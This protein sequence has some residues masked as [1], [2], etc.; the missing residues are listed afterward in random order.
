M[1]SSLADLVVN[2]SAN[3]ASLEQGLTRASS[4]VTKFGTDITRSLEGVNSR[5][6]SVG[7]AFHGLAAIVGAD[8]S[9]KFAK[10]LVAGS[11]EAQASLVDLG[12]R[13]GASAEQISALIPAAKLSGTSLEE[14][15][16]GAGK[17]SKS[18]VE[19][20]SGTGKS[21]AAF[22]ALGFSSADAARLLR[23]PA[24]GLAE[25]ATRLSAFADDGNK[26]AAAQLLLGKSGAQLL[27]FLHDLAEVGAD[28]V[29]VTQQQ[30]EAAKALQDQWALMQISS[31]QLKQ[32]FVGEL[33]PAL[34]AM[35][36]AWADLANAPGGFRDS[37]RQLIEQG[38]IRAYAQEAA[39]NLAKLAD[40]FS[41]GPRVVRPYAEAVGFV[42]VSLFDLGKALYGVSLAFS[43]PIQGFRLL[44]EAFDEVK[45]NFAAVKATFVEGQAPLS[46]KYYDAVTKAFID[47]ALSAGDTAKAVDKAKPSLTG[48]G[49]AAQESSASLASA[50][51]AYD[52]ALAAI[53]RASTDAT[54]LVGQ[55]GIKAQLD[56]LERAFSQSL[57]GFREYYSQRTALQ[58][59]SFEIEESRLRQDIATQTELLNGLGQQLQSLAPKGN[60]FKEINEF[61]LAYYRTATQ[62]SEAQAKLIGLQGQLN[63]KQVE[64]AQVG[65]DYIEQLIKQSDG[66][67]QTNRAL[68]SQ[69]TAQQR[70]N[71][72]IGLTK[73]Q[74]IALNI[75]RVEEDRATRNLL[76][77]T[78]AV[79]AYYDAQIDGLKRLGD[80]T[81]K[82]E[83]IQRVVDAF[84]E[85]EQIGQNV[86]ESLFEKGSDTFKQ[87]GATLK[88]FVLDLIYQLTV[89]PILVNLIA[90]VTGTSGGALAGATSPG[91]LLGLFSQGSS[92]FGGAGNAGAAGGLASL[93]SSFATSGA[94]VSLGLGATVGSSA[95]AAAA[96]GLSLGVEAGAT[97]AAGV[98]TTAG[99]AI[100][101]AIPVVGWA[102][103]AAAAIYSIIQSN[104]KP[105]PV[106]GQFGFTA[107]NVPGSAFEDNSFTASKFGNI[108]FLDQGT[109]QFSGEAGQAL[110]KSVAG[111]LDLFADRFTDEQIKQTSQNL[112]A[113]QFPHFSGTFTTEDFLAKYGDQILKQVATTAF[114][115]LDPALGKVIAGF[116]GTGQALTGFIG[117]LLV[118]HDLAAKLPTEVAANLERA[119]DSTQAGLDKITTFAAAFLNVQDVLNADPIADALANIKAQSRGAADT[120]ATMGDGLADLIKNFD[121]TAAAATGLA[122]A[123]QAYYNAEVALI[124]QIEQVKSSISDLFTNTIRSITLQTLDNAGKGN[125][126]NDE[127][128]QLQSQLF[129]ST[130]PAQIQALA[131][132]INDD[133]NQ[134]FGL[135]SPEEQQSQLSTFTD[136][137]RQLNDEVTQRLQDVESTAESTAADLLTQVRDALGDAIKQMADAA[138]AQQDAAG[139]QQDAAQTQL[140]AAQ[141]QLDAANTPAQPIVIAL[142]DFE[143]NG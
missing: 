34:S 53:Q 74:I 76:E 20:E 48:L 57:V 115:V 27:P 125:F 118:F 8:L 26:A 132:R 43:N 3:I 39:V 100:V 81:A 44:T 84:K 85:L 11:I 70:A 54:A 99:T 65:K 47:I 51:A 18:L 136:N 96:G 94:G 143:T 102:I 32:S 30:A 93:F 131:N 129:S 89:K 127:I 128:G 119:L 55:A 41:D 88:K 83:G 123:T 10:E 4:L 75:A 2:V 21:V 116:T 68:E 141:T 112:Q 45:T 92:L 22:K 69:I 13:V 86:F 15:A 113:L 29:L 101:A 61:A 121:G 71:E 78:P 104:K 72:E 19:L 79:Q 23:D 103:A 17:F 6:D 12:L 52:K 66:L 67:L 87:L 111:L 16:A 134:L 133:I 109:Q 62:V 95:A 126:L 122:T 58:A 37:L 46:T 25:V 77:L 91:G 1:A 105:T 14:V 120:L 138:G 137:L 33:I 9:F 36:K 49:T 130:D 50:A 142:P 24:A 7:N 97:A 60:S 42:V 107:P 59:Q 28:T 98:L 38:T 90:Q 40:L 63:A 114:D 140:E 110:N 139:A 117:G 124:A 64:G 5:L 35:L 106:E 56:D 31:D 73:S 82:G 108:G 135:L 80:A